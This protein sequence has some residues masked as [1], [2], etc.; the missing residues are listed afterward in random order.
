MRLP[1]VMQLL[2]AS[3][4]LAGCFGVPAQEAGPRAVITQV[5][6]GPRPPLVLRLLPDQ[7]YPAGSRIVIT[8]AGTGAAAVLTEGFHA[9]GAPAVSFDGERIL[10]AGKR[11]ASSRWAVYE[12][13]PS[14][15]RPN[16]VYGTEEADCCDPAYL[17]KGEIVFVCG[18]PSPGGTRSL[19]TA[20]RS[21]L[22]LERI[23]FGPGSAFDP[24]PLRDGRI[25]FS[26]WGDDARSALFLL[27]PDGRQLD[28]FHGHRSGPALKARPR[29]AA[30]LDV[31]FLAAEDGR[32]RPA[33][34]RRVSFARPAAPAG[35]L[36]PELDALSV[37]PLPDG[38]FL[39]GGRLTEGDTDGIFRL[40]SPAA[41]LSP[42][43]F[44][45]DPDWDEVEA[46][47]LLARP[48]PAGRPDPLKKEK[49]V[50]G[51]LVCYDADPHGPGH[52]P[53]ARSAS[54][55]AVRFLRAVPGKAAA[56]PL[57]GP[58]AET[59][60][61]TAPVEEDGSFFV[62]LPPDIPVRLETLDRKGRLISGSGWFWTRPGEAR[63]CFGCHENR[64]TAPR[65][66]PISAL[67]GKPHRVG[68][69]EAP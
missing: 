42:A 63:A 4:L 54:A 67:R 17:A 30:D 44:F 33:R 60:L 69:G 7:R 48:V 31:V 11:R 39:A 16:R 18:G 20:T 36:A 51:K 37:E 21:G 43:P 57:R 1:R 9:A 26:M 22:A 3:S 27:N 52:G 34:L 28:P 10:F 15:A 62:E 64:E 45:D 40:G 56:S 29:Q 58:R 2:A 23:S 32:T 46:V 25:V 55:A 53:T 50:T 13:D 35:A 41:R 24:A 65:N 5:P 19:Y 12:T 8:G 66:R 47:P 38:G 68:L 14:G 59:I 61:G 49:L 6:A